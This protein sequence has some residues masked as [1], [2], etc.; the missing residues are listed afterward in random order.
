MIVVDA[1]A[2]VEALVGRAPD[3][4]LFELLGGDLH[5]P[6]LIDVEVTSVL[7][8]FSLGGRVG[9]DTAENARLDLA[10]LDVVRHEFAPFADR[11][12]AL[13]HQFTNALLMVKQC[14]YR[15]FA[16]VIAFGLQIEALKREGVSCQRHLLTRL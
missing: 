2:M 9:I 4:R 16:G 10:G 6:H 12:W 5:A 7:R 14:H 13:R 11:V 3:P 1:S 8:G 15:F